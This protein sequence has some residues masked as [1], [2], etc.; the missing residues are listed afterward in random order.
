MCYPFTTSVGVG[1]G[2]PSVSTDASITSPSVEMVLSSF[3]TLQGFSL[4]VK[5]LF[6]W[7]S[8][9]IVYPPSNEWSLV[10][11]TRGPATIPASEAHVNFFV[12]E[13]A[14]EGLYVSHQVVN[15]STT[16]TSYSVISDV[17]LFSMSVR[18]VGMVV[19]SS[20]VVSCASAS[21]VVKVA[22]NLL[23]IF[24]RV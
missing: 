13:E 12:G 11:G 1:S 22:V 6:S 7:F 16:E 24:F 3:P 10:G 14:S 21:V 4:T 17:S 20:A 23:F 9:I 5:V 18:L 8:V 15:A 19:H 2:I